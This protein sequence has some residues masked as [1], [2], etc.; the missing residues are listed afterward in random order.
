MKLEG[1]NIKI[2]RKIMEKLPL[3]V[4][5]PNGKT[6]E[7]KII[8]DVDDVTE[9]LFH[10]KYNHILTNETLIENKFL[11]E[12]DPTQRITEILEFFKMNNFQVYKNNEQLSLTGGGSEN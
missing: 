12:S 8:M 4:I 6:F 3:M 10:V 11:F 2:I 7:M 5:A 1:E 9:Q